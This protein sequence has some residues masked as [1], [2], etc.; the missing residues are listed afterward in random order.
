MPRNAALISVDRAAGTAYKLVWGEQFGYGVWSS[1]ISPNASV[2]SVPSTDP[3]CPNG[4]LFELVRDASEHVDLAQSSNAT[5]AIFAAMVKR[6]LVIGATQWQTN[7][8]DVED[9]GCI[10]DAQMADKYGGWL[11]PVCGVAPEQ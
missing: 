5:R 6:L 8:S 1:P 9:D 3:G 4:C 2:P 10:T 7:Y 11:G